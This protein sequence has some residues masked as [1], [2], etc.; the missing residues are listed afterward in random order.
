[1]TIAAIGEWLNISMQYAR[2]VAAV[3]VLL[4]C[5]IIYLVARYI[6]LKV[7]DKVV[8]KTK[9]Y[10][11]DI[12]RKHRV[13]RRMVLV[14]PVLTL[15]FFADLF[16][17]FQAFIQKICISLI[18]M[19]SVSTLNGVLSAIEEIYGELPVSRERPIKGF[20]QI[21][22][23]I[24]VIFGLIVIVGVLIDRSPIYLLSGLGAMTAV[25]ILVFKDTIL[26]FVASVRVS[27]NGLIKIG[28]WISY[29]QHD[30]DGE[31]IDMALHS[32]RIRNWDKTITTIPMHKLLD[33]SFKNWQGM[34][35][36]GGRRIK[37]SL[38]IDMNSVRFLDDDLLGKLSKVRLLEGYIR[39]KKQEIEQFNQELEKDSTKAASS[40]R[41]TN[42][43]T[44]RA[45]IAAYLRS[46]PVIRKDMTF[47]V[48]HLDPTPKGIPIEV[49][50]FTDTTEWA[51]YEAIQ[52]DI[53]DHLLAVVSE[54][55]LR[56]F[57]E[58]F[59]WDWRGSK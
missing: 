20:L 39:D 17:G 34:V 10:W 3:G 27:S 15:W 38:S 1:M 54:F 47:L 33:E 45:Y 18:V 13:F 25:L 32:I 11:D 48:R 21:I 37:R 36:T 16:P 52:A 5:W 30:A 59:G 44:F 43:G 41:M 9:T 8:E 23:L 50:V 49:Y 12:F 24:L 42:F 2:L 40:R 31:V 58:P 46:L 53:F 56:V 4:L 51:K 22:K 28:D 26:S 55:D 57:Q 35:E 6:L 29:P 19:I 14:A 7:I